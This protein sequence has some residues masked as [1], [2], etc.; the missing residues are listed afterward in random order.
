[1][2]KTSLREAQV[3]GTAPM[4]LLHGMLGGPESWRPVV[5]ALADYP[6]AIWALALPGHGRPAVPVAGGFFA[7]VRA[8]A[9]RIDEP[10]HV[11]GYS[12]GGRVALGLAALVPDRVIEV[13]VVSAH[14]GLDAAARKERVLWERAQ[15][16]VLLRRGLTAYVDQFEALPIFA[17]QTRLGESARA[18]Q[19]AQREAHDALNIARALVELGSGEMPQLAP[20][21]VASRVPVHF[22]T[23][24]LDSKY[25]ALGHEAV[26][27]IP[28]AQ[29]H[30]IEDAGHNLTLEVPVDLARVI[31]RI[32]HPSLTRGEQTH[33]LAPV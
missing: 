1:M 8:L 9:A 12:M 26:S 21:L 7:N 23:G 24:S 10:C 4:L 5:A 17:T 16:D 28:G 11:V 3:P 25:V 32:H 19:R 22:V 18:A 31:A 27:Q 14:V 33:D 6:G 13:T 20:L 29:L 30:V 2:T 15:L